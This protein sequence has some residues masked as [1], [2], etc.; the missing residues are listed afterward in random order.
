MSSVLLANRRPKQEPIEGVDATSMVRV[1]LYALEGGNKKMMVIT[2]HDALHAAPISVLSPTF[3]L[4][5]HNWCAKRESCKLAKRGGPAIRTSHRSNT[6]CPVLQLRPGTI[7]CP[8]AAPPFRREKQVPRIA[9]RRSLGVVRLPALSP[10]IYQAPRF[11][12]AFSSTTTRNDICYLLCLSRVVH[13]LLRP[14]IFPI[15]IS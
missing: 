2:N 11:S 10:F 15:S 13:H 5:R 7:P 4:V 8:S 1:S 6:V 3:K 12:S 9:K 14:S